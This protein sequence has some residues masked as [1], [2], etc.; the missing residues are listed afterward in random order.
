MLYPAVVRS[1]ERYRPERVRE[2][3]G[4]TNRL[5]DALEQRLGPVVARTPVALKLEAEE[6]LSEACGRAGI[7]VTDC[8]LVPYEATAALAML[9]L[10]DHGILTVHFAA[11][12]PG[13][14]ALLLKFVPPETLERF[15]GPE[16]FA[17]AVDGALDELAGLLAMPQELRTLLVP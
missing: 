12:P 2:L 6:L 4:A 17:A 5:G 14:S 13:T 7:Q 8:Y 10:R 3:V 11:L 15:G 16:R 1:L 9:L